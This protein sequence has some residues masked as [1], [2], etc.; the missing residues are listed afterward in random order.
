[1]VKD[2]FA[3]HCKDRRVV[4]I[5]F[6]FLFYMLGIRFFSGI[7]FVLSFLILFLLTNSF[8]VRSNQ[9]L[10]ALGVALFASVF[11]F[12]KG[13]PIGYCGLVAL[14]VIN[15][16][17]L[18]YYV[19]GRDVRAD[20]KAALK[21]FVIHAFISA[22]LYLIVP[23]EL[24]IDINWNDAMLQK[25]T[26]LYM[27]FYNA[28][29]R[30]MLSFLPLPRISGLAWEPGCLQLIINLFICLEIYDK[31]GIKKLILPSIVLILTGS[32]T[33]YIIWA[34]NILLYILLSSVSRIAALV[35]VAIVAAAIVVPVMV[36]N[37]TNKLFIGE[38]YIS[39]SGAVRMR[40]LFTGIEEVKQYPLF[41]I[42]VS[43]LANSKQYQQLE[44]AGLSH[45]NI[46]DN[47][48]V[49]Y[50]YAAGGYC[51]GFFAMHMF[52]GV[53]GLL[54]LYSFFKCRLWKQWSYGRYWYF[55]PI[56]ISLTLVSE[57]IS[58]SSFFL[59]LCFYNLLTK[60]KRYADINRYSYI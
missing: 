6:L 29:E 19:H 15:A 55:L 45:F 30:H 47:W 51:N 37:I 33:G 35:P 54:F 16:V 23:K 2:F 50:D 56:I 17:L 14:Y 42:D 28:G 3:L 27:F 59:F 20:F 57:P 1:M 60:E 4:L 36:T 13:S 24:L 12:L 40:D 48:H 49:A 44:D 22:I 34:I 18:V 43:D 32:T 38:D 46:V 25:K 8:K 7:G 5:L 41:G 52:W 58:N 11:Q 39:G 21:I 10:T 9:L 26:L 53:L 31:A